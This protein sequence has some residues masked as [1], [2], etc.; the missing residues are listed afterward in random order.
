MQSAQ[1]LA[2]QGIE[3]TVLR[4]LTVADL[5]AQQVASQIIPGKPVVILEETCSN[6]GIREALAWELEKSCPGCLVEGKDLGP[7]FVPHGGQKELYRHCGLDEQ[8][9]AEFAREVLSR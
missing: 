4:L 8:S 5:P 9:I 7:N 3:A 1:L 2:Q 6:S